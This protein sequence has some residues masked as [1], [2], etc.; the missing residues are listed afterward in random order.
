MMEH[1]TGPVVVAGA[2]Q[3]AAQLAQSLRQGGY[4]GQIVMIGDEPMPPYERPPLSK[5]YLSGKREAVRLLLRKPEFWA[6][7]AVEMRLGRAV[8]TVDRAGRTVM[9]EGGEAV[10]YGTLVWAAGGRP[11][12]LSC[13][14][15]ALQCVHYVRALADIDRLKAD[16]TEAGRRVVIVGGGYIGLEA[17]AVLRGMGHC[18]TILEMQDRLLARVTSPVVS[19]FLLDLHRRHGVEV[20]L[21][22]CVVELR[23]REGRVTGLTLS[24]GDVIEADLVIVGIGI[25]PNVEPLREAGVDCPNGVRVDEFCRTA[26]PH[27]MAIGDCALHP[28][29]HAG[30]EIRLESVQN[31]IDQAKTAAEV[32][33]GRPQAYNALPWFWSDQYG[34]KMQTAGLCAGHDRVVVRGRAGATPFTAAYLRRGRLIAL[35]CLGAPKDFMQGRALLVAGARV[36]PDMLVDPEVELLASVLS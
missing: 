23:G 19:G 28:N 9:L 3:A 5:D 8:T 20:R 25:I 4:A 16:L 35:D 21:T 11:R 24:D 10:A 22:T 12:R 6:E 30:A 18:V 32:I 7:R 27:V 36:D 1:G 14:G 15:A 33:L 26:D 13:P 34:V 29:H 17:A 2:G 31:A